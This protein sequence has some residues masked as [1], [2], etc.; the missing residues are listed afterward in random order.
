MLIGVTGVFACGMVAEPLVRIPSGFAV[1]VGE[2]ESLVSASD[3]RAYQ[4][5]AWGM[6][7]AVTDGLMGVSVGRRLILFD[8]GLT[9]SC[10]REPQSHENLENQY[11]PGTI[12]WALATKYPDDL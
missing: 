10:G 3:P 11:P 1:L 8:F 4:G 7:I 12:I 5:E 9:P 6:R 2:V